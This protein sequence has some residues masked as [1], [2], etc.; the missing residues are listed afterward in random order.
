M[1]TAIIVRCR[2]CGEE[3]HDPAS[4]ARKIGSTCWSRLTRAQKLE[5]LA[6]AAAEDKPGY[7]PPTRPASAQARRNHAELQHVVAPL[8]VYP[9]YPG[10]QQ[11]ADQQDPAKSTILCAPHGGVLGSCALCRRDNDP[12]L[13]ADRIIAAVQ[14]LSMDQRLEV[15]RAAAIRRYRPATTH[16]LEIGA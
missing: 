1:I 6:L 15:E 5:M 12:K 9:D 16:Q 7:I 3:L 13:I 10:R 8:N 2:K 11:E 14:R 4:K